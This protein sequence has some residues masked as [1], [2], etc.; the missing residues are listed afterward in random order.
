MVQLRECIKRIVS[1][2]AA[3]YNPNKPFA[4]AK[5]DIKDG[6]WRM[7]VAKDAA[8]NFCYV[9]PAVSPVNN[10]DD[11]ELVVPSSLQMGWCNPPPIF[12]QP[13]KRHET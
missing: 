11:I 5:V 2:M 13:Q 4:F 12:V 6:F 3:N 9:L 8:W 7:R 10:I 1:T